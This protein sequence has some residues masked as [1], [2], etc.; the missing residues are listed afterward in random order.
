MRRDIF[1]YIWI[2]NLLQGKPIIIEGGK[3]TRDP[4]YVTDTVDVWTAAVESKDPA[5]IGESFQ[6]SRGK[7]YNIED[8]A[9]M[10]LNKL[11]GSAQY[12]SYRPGEEGQRESFNITKAGKML[13]YNPKVDL[14]EG[15]DLLIEDMK[16][17]RS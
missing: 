17:S 9:G 15:I 11:P 16:N 6:V 1:L 12:T 7:E 10:V 8:I 5:I 3:Q 13:G 4:C 2:K 14:S